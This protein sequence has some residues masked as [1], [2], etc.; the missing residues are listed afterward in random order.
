MLE[1]LLSRSSGRGYKLHLGSIGD[2]GEAYRRWQQRMR[3]HQRRDTR[4]L[5]SSDRRKCS[6]RRNDKS[7]NRNNHRGNLHEP[8]RNNS[9][10]NGQGNYNQPTVLLPKAGSHGPFYLGQDAR[11]ASNITQSPTVCQPNNGT[12]L[13]TASAA[14]T[15]GIRYGTTCNANNNPIARQLGTFHTGSG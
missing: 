2:T 3:S 11:N 1:V 13:S 15:P 7:C 4:S 9:R 14:G 6:S 10:N 12:P 8:P 5:F